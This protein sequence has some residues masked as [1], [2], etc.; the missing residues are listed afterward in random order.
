MTG[1]A[2]MPRAST[3][4]ILTIA[5]SDSSGG[6][7][8][9]AD[10]KTI[11]ALGGY[12]MSVVTAVTAQNTVGVQG[13]EILP[14]RFISLQIK[15]VVDDI[16][17]D[18]IKSGMLA[19]TAVATVVADALD[20]ISAPYVCDPVMVSTSGA[21]LMD[22]EAVEVYKTRLF[23]RATVIT[24]NLP[25][26]EA[27]TGQTITTIDHMRTAATELLA[28]GPQAVLLKGG[29]GHDDGLVDLLLTAGGEVL[30]TAKRVKTRHTHGTGCTMASAIATGLALGLGV[31]ESVATAHDY[32][33]TAIRNAPGLG[34]GHGPLGLGK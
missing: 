16:G 5:G 30:L 26:A 2:D 21:R 31:A 17:V 19:S 18:S 23:P 10:I 6:A 9:Q 32:V 13:V 27:L 24:P 1:G 28:L 8:I 12:A 20:E 29:H 4:R 14:P 34:Q 15:S 3:P 11:T 22:H 25:E 33:Q 7:G